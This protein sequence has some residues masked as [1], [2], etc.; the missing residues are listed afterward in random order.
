METNHI[1]SYYSYYKIGSQQLY[2]L[3]W[4]PACSGPWLAAGRVRHQVGVVLA[5][6]RLLALEWPPPPSD[7]HDSNN[8]G[9]GNNDSNGDGTMM[10]GAVVVAPAATNRTTMSCMMSLSPWR[11]PTHVPTLSK[12]ESC[13]L[14]PLLP[15]LCSIPY[16]ESPRM[17]WSYAR[18]STAASWWAI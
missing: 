13:P 15:H 6:L 8:S 18:W 10:T 14:L 11:P 3:P 5:A 4:Q 16:R 9:A 17:R 7:N 2:S 12:L 1:L